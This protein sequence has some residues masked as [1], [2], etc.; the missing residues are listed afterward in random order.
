MQ[1]NTHMAFRAKKCKIK[2][3]IDLDYMAIIWLCALV[4]FVIVEAMT[5]QMLCI[6]FAASSLV[7]LVLALIG[8]PEWAQIVVFFLCTAVLLIFTRPIVKRFM[9]KP[10]ER[11]NADR[12]IG[13][14]AVVIQEI[15]NDKAEGQVSVANQVWTARST[16]GE[17]IPVDTK[18]EVRSIEGVKAIVEKQEQE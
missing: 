7:S 5:V 12:I 9:N 10:R 13:M 2:V 6:W 3:V 8:V 17:I 16:S 4:F 1:Y 11:T 15:N 14:T 18:V